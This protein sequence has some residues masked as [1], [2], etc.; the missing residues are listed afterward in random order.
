MISPTA[1]SRDNSYICITGYDL[2][3]QNYNRSIVSTYEP[4]FKE[5]LGEKKSYTT[6]I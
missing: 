3:A 1:Q 5:W 4:K 6:I 2:G